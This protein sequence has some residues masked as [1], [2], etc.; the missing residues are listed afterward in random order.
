[1]AVIE[2]SFGHITTKTLASSGVF[3]F[4]RKKFWQKKCPPHPNHFLKIQWKIHFLESH[5][6]GRESLY[7]IVRDYLESHCT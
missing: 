6:L 4:F 3:G 2:L 7:L 1:M 5:F